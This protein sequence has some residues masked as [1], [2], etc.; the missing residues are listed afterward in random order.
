VRNGIVRDLDS[1]SLSRLVGIGKPGVMVAG[2]IDVATAVEVRAHV[3][4][5]WGR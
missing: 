3:L 5:F 1:V 4:A 2:G